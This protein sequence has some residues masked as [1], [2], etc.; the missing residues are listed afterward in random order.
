MREQSNLIARKEP[1]ETNGYALS[2]K[3]II[4]WNKFRKIGEL[5]G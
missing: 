5:G 3:N 2:V 4:R 1:F